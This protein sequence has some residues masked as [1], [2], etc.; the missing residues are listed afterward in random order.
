MDWKD[1]E[2][3]DELRV[4][5]EQIGAE[6]HPLAGAAKL[7][8]AIGVKLGEVEAPMQKTD[9]FDIDAVKPTTD[10]LTFGTMA[11]RLRRT[12]RVVVKIPST[13][14]DHSP[15]QAGLNTVTFIIERDKEKIVP[16]QVAKNIAEACETRYRW[17]AGKGK[18]VA[19]EVPCYPIQILREATAEDLRKEREDALKSAGIG[20]TA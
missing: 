4:F 9:A 5:A 11:A 6:F 16:I 3:V 10:Q 7:R 15:V 13:E 1:S 12:P 8:R 18:N 14:A 20:A 2:N 17:D 19:R